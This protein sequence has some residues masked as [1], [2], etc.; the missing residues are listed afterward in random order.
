MKKRSAGD[1]DG[2]CMERKREQRSR[3]EEI[4]TEK[5]EAIERK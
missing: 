3:R 2:D 4:C 1:D 5:E